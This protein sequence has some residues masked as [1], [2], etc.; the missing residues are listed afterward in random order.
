MAWRQVKM[1]FIPKPGKSDYTEAKAYSPI[2]P[3]SFLLNMME[4][5]VDRHTRDGVL[6]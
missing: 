2:S 5:L 1:T 4:K 3:S 6:K